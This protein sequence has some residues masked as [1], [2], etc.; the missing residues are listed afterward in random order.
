MTNI[1]KIRQMTTKEFADFAWFV[2]RCQLCKRLNVDCAGGIP[3]AEYDKCTPEFIH[4]LESE[5]N[6]D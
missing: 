4:W 1:E 6:D 3:N 2:R 5:V